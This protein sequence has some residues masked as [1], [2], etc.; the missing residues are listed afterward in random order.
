MKISATLY[1]NS[2]SSRDVKE[3]DCLVP[4]RLGRV[5][6]NSEL[7]LG[8]A[9]SLSNVI[10]AVRRSGQISRP[11]LHKATGLSRTL[12]SKYSDRAISLNVLHQGALG[13]STGG[14]T[15]RILQFNP[16]AGA[17]LVAELGVSGMS[18]AI[19]DLGGE[20]TEIIELEGDISLGP[21]SVLLNVEKTFDRIIAK[22]KVDIWGIGI[23]L[24][25]P[26]EFA[27]GIAISPPI[28]PGWDRY[29]VRDRLSKIYNVPVWVDNDVNLMA[30]GTK[31]KN[32]HEKY[33]EFI[34]IKI[35][36]GIGAGI[37]TNGL[38][39][40]GAQGCAGDIGHI[41][42]EEASQIICRCGNLG[43]LEAIAGGFALGREANDAVTKNESKFLS[44]QLMINRVL[45]ARDVIEGAKSGDKWCVDAI[46]RAG[47]QVGKSLATLVNFHNP[48]VIVIGGGISAA[49]D[50]LLASIRET[51]FQR[52]L[53]LATRDLE[54]RLGEAADRMGLIGATEMVISELFKPESLKQWI[55]LGYPDSTFQYSH[56]K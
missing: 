46:T 11:E 42:V 39:H 47:H 18:L 56:E 32:R 31:V 26:V 25:G 35:G 6:N 17:I 3:V 12:I 54:I 45:D 15:P 7:T 52:S 14:R 13:V 9:L 28:M 30:L 23:G 19:S 55:N 20:L 29:P 50:Q 53:P 40:R 22:T 48:S 5:M 1:L 4:I 36:S 43:C 8:D 37:F 49:G 16:K 41:R 10:G 51:V 2:K 27:S 33:H 44:N 24:P 34:Y 21:E 38:L